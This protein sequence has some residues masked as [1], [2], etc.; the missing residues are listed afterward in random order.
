MKS[1][2]MVDTEEALREW[3]RPD[4]ELGWPGSSTVEMNAEEIAAFLWE[5]GL[6]RD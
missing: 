5:R 2:V 6:L 1:D 4:E 3:A